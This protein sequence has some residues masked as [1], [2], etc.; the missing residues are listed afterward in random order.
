[1]KKGESI[2]LLLMG[3][4]HESENNPDSRIDDYQE[5]RDKKRNTIHQHAK[6]YK[7]D[8]IIHTGDL[9][10]T[11]TPGM[12]FAGRVMSEW[13]EMPAPIV[14][15][16]GNHDCYGNMNTFNLTLG[17]F[18]QNIGIMNIV[19][20]ENPYIIEKNGFKLAI[21]GAS[22]HHRI[23]IDEERKDY[24]VEEK[25][26][27][28]QLHIVHGYLSVTNK[29][30]EHTLIDQVL[31]TKADFTLAGH[32]HLGF[33]TV[34]HENK[35]FANPGAIARIT[36]DKKEIARM[37][38]ILLLEVSTI[39][40]SS[41]ITE[42]SLGAEKGE[43]VLSREKIEAKEKKERKRQ[44]IKSDIK[45]ATINQH[46]SL[47][48]IIKEIAKTK[49]I[50]ESLL[51][52]TLDDILE[53]RMA[54][55]KKKYIGPKIVRVVLEN[56]QR[57]KYTDIVLDKGLN[58]FVGES[59]K[60]KSAILRGIDWVYE[61]QPTGKRMIKRGETFAKVT[62]YYE[63]GVVISRYTEL[64]T[65]GKNGFYI[66]DPITDEET[67]ENTKSLPLV[68]EK[69]GHNILTIDD[70]Y[71][72]PLNFSK[73]GDTWFLI[74]KGFTPSIKA[75][76]IGSL[77]DIHIAD[78]VIRDIDKNTKNIEL[79]IKKE[80]K[81]I[82][83]YN[84]KIEAFN[85]IEEIEAQVE[86]GKKLIKEIQILVDKKTAIIAL[87][88][89]AK[90]IDDVFTQIYWILEST[91][92]LSNSYVNISKLKDKCNKVF[93]M[94]KLKNQLVETNENIEYCLQVKRDTKNIEN[95]FGILQQLKELQ[96]NRDAKNKLKDTFTN[97][98]N[99]EKKISTQLVEEKLVIKS[100]EKLRNSSDS[101]IT[102]KKLIE[103]RNKVVEKS[104][105]YKNNLELINKEQKLI[106]D[107]DLETKNLLDKYKDVL[108]KAEQCP[109]CHGNIDT[110]I[111]NNIINNYI[112]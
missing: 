81:R 78:A 101:L 19:S 103:D 87:Q 5:T 54:L 55:S 16:V 17:K 21:S 44:K 94:K 11:H 10:D 82:D 24:I 58:M 108:L 14:C 111:V 15:V 76:L 100:T 29:P 18:I 46:T 99:E 71:E 34:Y 102:I 42:L 86:S 93:Q 112:K 9:F 36:A 92:N 61:N 41:K 53:K 84:E 27:D 13:N 104:E 40:G 45:K 4:I 33:E 47:E 8:G 105:V 62:I 2:R 74:G 64:K 79:T 59:G 60:G 96:V 110:V 28:Y 57:H 98:T 83:S 49:G 66:Y 35:I 30:Y 73:Q 51:K 3:D 23:D 20:K 106:V 72:I 91:K 50:N 52:R 7:V 89:E 22:H 32:D 69:I 77:Y 109:V 90:R 1:M 31:D 85:Y 80:E 26:G 70:D 63:S 97:L 75:K 39:D 88:S 25:V 43:N 6:K 107:F 68:Q 38:K 67:F 48:E 56:F 12:D 95:V 65:G 37:P